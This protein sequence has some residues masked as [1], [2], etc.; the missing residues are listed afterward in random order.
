VR[1]RPRA[2]A[3][4]PARAPARASRAARARTQYC[5]FGKMVKG[6]EVLRAMEQA[7]AHLRVHAP[8]NAAPLLRC[9]A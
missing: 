1:A 9:G 6:D 5:V 4:A 7:R 8:R 3:L 2:R